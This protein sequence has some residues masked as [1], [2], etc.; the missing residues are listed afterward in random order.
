NGEHAF[1]SPLLESL[2]AIIGPNAP[3][4][5]NLDGGKGTA[6]RLGL[7]IFRNW[8]LA[9][10]WVFIAL[11]LSVLPSYFVIGSFSGH[12]TSNVYVFCLYS[13]LPILLS[14]IFTS[15]FIIKHIENFKRIMNDEEMK[16]RTFFSKRS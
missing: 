3:L 1:G 10:V 4:T 9:C 6:A 15:L 11:I 12:I 8:T 5:M 13:Q 2:A 16:L 7:M 14:L